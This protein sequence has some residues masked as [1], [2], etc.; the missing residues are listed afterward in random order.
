MARSF[1]RRAVWLGSARLEVN[2]LDPTSGTSLVRCKTPKSVPLFEKGRAMKTFFFGS[3]VVVSLFLAA[4]SALAQAVL[5]PLVYITEIHVKPGQ[6]AAYEAAR[7]DVIAHLRA[8]RSSFG[9]TES[10]GED[11]VYRRITPIDDYADLDG[12]FAE[13]AEN[14]LARGILARLDEAVDHNSSWVVRPRPDLGY[15]PGTPRLTE[16]E[17]GLFRYAFLYFRRDA[18]AEFE[19]RLKA[20]AA[21]FE[22]HGSPNGLVV[23]QVVVGADT[24]MYLVRIAARDARDFYEQQASQSPEMAADVQGA[25]R[26]L[27]QLYRRMDTSLNTVVPEL[28]YQ[29]N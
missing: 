5:P 27:R 23:A 26:N 29:P 19:P 16:G 22:S 8:T 28:A 11:Q 1:R 20:L 6:T 17:I 7:H 9:F 2:L 21:A 25:I 12:M 15:T 13:R 3:V 18:R 4:S 10:R 14:P 24:P